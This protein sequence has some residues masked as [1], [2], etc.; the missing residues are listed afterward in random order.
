AGGVGGDLPIDEAFVARYFCPRFSQ[1]GRWL[2]Y[3]NGNQIEVVDSR[4][5]KP[6]TV[7]PGE[8]PA[9]GAG[10]ASIVYTNGQSGK[11]RT[12]WTAPFSLARGE[13]TGPPQP[14]TFGPGANLGAA[15]S[16]D[17][18]VI[19][20]SAVTETLNLQQVSFDYHT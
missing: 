6:K 2:L 17:G 5:G 3:Q 7:A 20:F 8:Y 13:V 11:S 10:S 14:L 16:R 15:V 4:G 19:A 12:L 9:W 1:D 18:R